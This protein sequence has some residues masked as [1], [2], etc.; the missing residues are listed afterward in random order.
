MCYGNFELPFMCAELRNPCQPGKTQ[1]WDTLGASTKA[2]QVKKQKTN[3]E[4]LF[5]II[6]RLCFHANLIV[7]QAAQY[8]VSGKRTICLPCGSTG[9]IK[10]DHP[11][12]A[13]SKALSTLLIH[14][15]SVMIHVP[16][17]ILPRALPS[18]STFLEH[19]ASILALPLLVM[20]MLTALI[21][22][23]VLGLDFHNLVR[24]FTKV[25]QLEAVVVGIVRVV[26]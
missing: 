18:H 23:E 11:L 7:K 8:S 10:T 20:D 14:Q 4:L 16:F 15:D 17:T 6:E 26:I 5:H 19:I 2:K 25:A 22:G 9:A 24:K 21:L 12:P 3:N 13:F 1:G